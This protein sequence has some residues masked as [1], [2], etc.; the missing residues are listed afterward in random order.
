MRAGLGGKTNCAGGDS[1]DG[2]PDVE[3]L[4]EVLKDRHMAGVQAAGRGPACMAPSG[5]PCPPRSR[6]HT[7]A[8]RG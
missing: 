3:S 7:W 6:T 4:P 5:S 2:A 1:Q 8:E